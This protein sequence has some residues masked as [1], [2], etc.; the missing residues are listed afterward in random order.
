[1]DGL[2]SSSQK[3]DEYLLDLPFTV[4]ELLIWYIKLILMK[5]GLSHASAL[6]LQI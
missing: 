6:V 4:E 1:M 5:K 3:N 2:L